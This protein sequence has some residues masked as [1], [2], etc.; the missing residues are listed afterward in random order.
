MAIGQIR[1]LKNYS[2]LSNSTVWLNLALIFISMGFVA[3]SAPNYEAAAFSFGVEPGPVETHAFV[4]L[5]L[6]AKVNGIM[7]IVV[8]T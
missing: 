3:H 1:T 6:W 2:W 7:N 4:T 8:C 5:P